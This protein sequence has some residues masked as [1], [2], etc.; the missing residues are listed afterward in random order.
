MPQRG[1]ADLAVFDVTG[2]R[3]ATLFHGEAEP[4]PHSATWD[5][6][7]SDGSLAP[8]GV[9]RCVLQTA[10]GRQARSLVLSR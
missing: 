1:D 9:Y 3:V 2:R 5:G 8:S 7:S 10:A 6:R 4:G